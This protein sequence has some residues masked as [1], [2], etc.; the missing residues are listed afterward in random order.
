MI[1]RKF[2]AQ[3]IREY[4][5]GEFI[6]NSLGGD[7]YSGTKLQKTPLGEKIIVCTSRPGLIV[8]RK[9]QNIRQLTIDLKEKFKLENP[10][11]EISE[12]EE[13]F[14]DAG[15]VAG[16]VASNLERFG[17]AKFKGIAHKMMEEVMRAGA[18]GVEILISGTVPSER[19][20]T[21]RFW[22]GY[23]KKCGDAAQKDVRKA[24]TAAQLKRGIIGVQV[25]IMPP[26]I[27]LPDDIRMR[28][29]P[30]ELK[31]AAQPQKPAELK[32]MKQEKTEEKAEKEPKKK[33]K[34]KKEQPQ[35]VNAEETEKAK[36]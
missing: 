11:I 7:G 23:L 10:Q 4:E 13:V 1:E 24:Y 28:T 29:E 19:A 14:L 15:V 25:R 5:I 18:R 35:E 36:E 26:N 2:V 3:K 16:M 27:R 17:T 21:W 12:V 8:G 22:Q 20:K 6:A 34:P 32:E 31:E 9:G 33:S 30:A